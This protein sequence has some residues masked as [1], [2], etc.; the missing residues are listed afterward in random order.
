MTRSESGT[1]SP[2]GATRQE[3]TSEAVPLSPAGVTWLGLAVNAL[4]GAAKIAGGLIFHSQ[5]ILADGVHSATDL[6]TDAAVLTG[7]KYSDNPA[8]GCHPYGHRR[9]STL[10]AM[11]VGLLLLG[12]GAWI[13]VDSLRKLQEQ[14]HDQKS[15]WLPLLLALG[16]IPL[17]EILFRLTRRVGRQSGNL[18][19]KANAWHHRSDCFTSLAAAA[20]I[21]GAWIGGASWAFLDHVTAVL[22]VG[23]LALAA[24]RI[25]Y[26]S[27][28]ELIDA[29]PDEDVL[30]QIH[31]L[32]DDTPG[33]QDFHA[34]RARE[35]G[36]QL[37]MDM[38]VL[39]EPDLTVREGHDIATAVKR[40]LMN[41][42]LSF[43]EVVV[44]IE[45]AEPT[46]GHPAGDVASAANRRDRD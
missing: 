16:T 30:D 10:V 41:S 37:E 18:S 29:S 33:V 2:A 20:G 26:E 5:A 23:F 9:I 4:L 35:V 7:L 17:K 25:V 12:A 38:H 19:L 44:H 32:I 15:L 24:V 28:S 3:D 31:E 46:A 42:S 36:G 13:A 1:D 45:P 14:D 27:A 8:D 11:F 22:L 6:V 39:V 34:V 21:G 40:K 43:A